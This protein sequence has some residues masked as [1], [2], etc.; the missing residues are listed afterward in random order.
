MIINEI[1]GSIDGEAR[2]AGEL[3][4]FVRTNGCNLKCSWCFAAGKDGKF[5]YVRL[6]DGSTKPLDEV[7]VGDEIMTLND[8]Q[9]LT[10]TTVQDI[11]QHTSSEY[12]RL[13]FPSASFICTPEHPFWSNGKWEKA[14]NLK[15]GDTCVRVS[16]YEYAEYQ[17]VG[18]EGRKLLRE[19]TETSLDFWKSLPLV[20]KGKRN[21]N[22]NESFEQHNFSNLKYLIGKG[23]LTKDGFGNGGKLV[24][25][26]IDGN[27]E[28]DNPSNLVVITKE[29]HDQLHARGFNFGQSIRDAAK[30]VPLLSHTRSYGDDYCHQLGHKEKLFINLTCAPFN[31][32]LV[33]DIY[34]HNCDSKYT[35]GVEKGVNMTVDEIVAK[36]KELGNKNVTFTGGEPLLQKDADDLIF[37]L[38]NEG[39]DVSIETNG[40]IKWSDRLWFKPTLTNL[41][42][43]W[44]ATPPWVCADFKARS[45]GEKE[46]MLPMEEFATLRDNDVLKFVVGS[47]QELEDAYE[48][49]QA[50]RNMGCKCW[51]YLSPVFGMIEP[52]EI[53]EFMQEKKW[54]DRVR[55][56][57]QLH[58]FFWDPNKRGV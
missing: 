20:N 16:D 57:L 43:I 28:N 29:L 14:A 46:K 9:E 23:Y 53:V 56:Q 47:R 10:I 7:V 58:K 13:V 48:V 37:A 19:Y 24:V 36:C 2:R 17:V 38:A 51:V 34:V 54:Q 21:G 40:S 33:S 8:A 1:F 44:N 3:A 6:P 50:I 18:E 15:I 42:K 32:F 39:F 52:K 26:H 4:T 35:W 25:H 11:H 30:N 22:Y 49:T 41:W 45:S 12:E 31:T 5:P 55:A 27:P